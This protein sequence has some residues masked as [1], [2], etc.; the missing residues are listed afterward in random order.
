MNTTTPLETVR[1]VDLEKYQGKWY[2]IAHFPSTFLS[3][4]E[5][6]TATYNLTEKGYVEVHN[7][8][9]KQ[10]TG[11]VKE[12]TGK[13]FPVE[14]SNNSKL[15]V[16]FFW[17]FRADYWILDIVG[18]Y[19]YVSV[20]GPTR[21]YAWILSRTPDPDEDV[22]SDMMKTLERKGFDVSRFIRTEHT[23]EGEIR[24]PRIK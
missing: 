24:K 12:I 23:S 11:K 4:C 5:N 8:C 19:E 14:G 13:A 21:D 22:V 18:D 17:P 2:D 7:R 9:V 3:G 16:Q 1:E 10:K 20:G 6:I 15:K